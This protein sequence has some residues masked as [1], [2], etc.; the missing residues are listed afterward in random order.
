MNVIANCFFNLVFRI[1]VFSSNRAVSL[2]LSVFLL[3]WY[4]YFQETDTVLITCRFS[5]TQNFAFLYIPSISV[6][7]EKVLLA[8]HC[9]SF[10]LNGLQ[11]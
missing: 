7:R 8:E 3:L 9:K 5:V 2:T 11:G 6:L 10:W 1:V 4:Y